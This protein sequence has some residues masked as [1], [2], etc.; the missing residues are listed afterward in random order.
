MN[1]TYIVKKVDLKGTPLEKIW[2]SIEE[3]SIDNY[4]WENN[5]YEPITK[6]KLFYTD[7]NLHIFFK[8][9]EEEISVTYFNMNEDVYKNSCVEFFVNP[10]PDKDDR[11]LNFEMNAAGTLLLGLGVN[12][13][14]RKRFYI[15]NFKEFFNIKSLVTEKNLA[16][17]EGNYWTVEYSI[18]LT[19]LEEIYGNLNMTS[20]HKMKANFYKCG[21]ETRYPHYGCLNKLLNKEPDFHRPEYFGDLILD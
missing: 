7:T 2:D 8:S 12:R 3:L 17:Y 1:K 5:G 9:Y 14:E 20:G 18:P 15:E 10:N 4:L 11:Y 13:H 16:N 21:D 6:A 19:F